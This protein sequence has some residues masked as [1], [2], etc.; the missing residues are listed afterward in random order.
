MAKFQHLET[1]DFW[2]FFDVNSVVLFSRYA[3]TGSNSFIV[4]FWLSGSRVWVLIVKRVVVRF[5][6]NFY[7]IIWHLFTFSFANWDFF[8]VNWRFLW[9]RV[10][11]KWGCFLENFRDGLVR[12]FYVIKVIGKILWGVFLIGIIVSFHFHP[13]LEFSDSRFGRYWRIQKHRFFGKFCKFR[14]KVK[15]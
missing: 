1:T 8:L 11:K 7:T 12:I 6:W 14:S 2:Y 4:Y 9:S 15:S 10:K 5:A 3:R 13:I